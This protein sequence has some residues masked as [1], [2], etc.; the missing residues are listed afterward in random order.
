MADGKSIRCAIF[1]HA[2]PSEGWWG[3][4][5][6]GRVVGGHVDGCGRTHFRIM[7]RCPRCKAEYTAARFHGTDP[8]IT[9]A[10]TA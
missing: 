4:G 9:K 5:L 7:L 1:G 8:A 6:Y 3:D 2:K 10:E